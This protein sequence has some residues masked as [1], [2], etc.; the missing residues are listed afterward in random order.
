[1]QFRA[2]PRGGARLPQGLWSRAGSWE[3]FQGSSGHPST[4]TG[5]VSLGVPF[6]GI[7]GFSLQSGGPRPS[8]GG[9]HLFEVQFGLMK[10]REWVLAA[11][12]KWVDALQSVEGLQRVR[13][14]KGEGI[15]P[16]VSSTEALPELPA[17]CPAEF[18]LKNAMLEFTSWL[19][20]LRT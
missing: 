3:W 19:S 13:F 16:Q 18:R 15:L 14:P 11:G 17:C 8:L 20:C 5:L 12:S 4:P 2:S 6:S 7:R 9:A 1:M 10:L